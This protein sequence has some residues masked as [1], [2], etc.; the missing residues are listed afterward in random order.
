MQYG[1]DPVGNITV[2]T[3][4]TNSTQ[5]QTFTYDQVDR[6]LSAATNAAGSG[7]Y[8][9][10][11]QYNQIGNLTSKAGVTQWYSDTLH[12][13]AVTH[14]GG[15]QKFWYDAN[16]NMTKRIENGITYTQTWDAENRLVVVTNTTPTAAKESRCSAKI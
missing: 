4:V 15:V 2:I 16:G 1:Y 14:L 5:K 12:K 8:N 7:Q 13:H 11:Y 9:E 10:S 3:D 6:L